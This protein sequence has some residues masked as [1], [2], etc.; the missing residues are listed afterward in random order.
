MFINKDIN[1]FS[2][3]NNWQLVAQAELVAANEERIQSSRS[4]ASSSGLSSGSAAA[5]QQITS[6]LLSSALASAGIPQ[7]ST[8]RSHSKP[9][10]SLYYKIYVTLIVKTRAQSRG[11][12]LYIHSFLGLSSAGPSTSRGTSTSRQTITRDM[13]REAM[14]SARSVTHTSS[15]MQVGFRIML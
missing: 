11:D 8:S 14:A 10:I 13:V 6:S 9:F 3:I 1:T 12:K 15:Q 4:S 2:F 5:H 7:A